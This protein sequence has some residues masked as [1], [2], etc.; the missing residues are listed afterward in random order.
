[1]RARVERGGFSIDYVFCY[2]QYGEVSAILVSTK[3]SGSA[4]VEFES[5]H[6]AVCYYLMIKTVVH[7]RHNYIF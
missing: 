7:T 1:M 3:K 4:V 2:I 5:T 6:S